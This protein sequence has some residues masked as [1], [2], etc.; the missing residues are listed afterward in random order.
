M[1][2]SE[3]SSCNRATSQRVVRGNVASGCDLLPPDFL[4]IPGTAPRIG[5]GRCWR[6]WRL[7]RGEAVQTFICTRL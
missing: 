4:R 7:P 5:L 1:S 2:C 6:G 3:I